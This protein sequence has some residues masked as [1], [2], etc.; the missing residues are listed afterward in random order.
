MA[1]AAEDLLVRIDATTE[2]LRREMRRGDQ[3]VAQSSSKIN[4]SLRRVDGGFRRLNRTVGMAT[5]AM[6]LFGVSIGGAAFIRSADQALKSVQE[7]ERSALALGETT[8]SIQELAYAF[9]QFNLEQDDVNDALNTLADRAQDAV[10]GTQGMIDDFGLL[11]VT[12]DDLRGKSPGELFD[13]IAEAVAGIE[14]PTARSA[15]VV[16]TFGDDLGRKLIPLLMEGA[17]GLKAYRDEAHDLNAVLGQDTVRAGSDAARELAKVRAIFDAQFNNAIAANAGAFSELSDVLTSDGFQTAMNFFA[18][19]MASIATESAKAAEQVGNLIDLFTLD[20][21]P[22]SLLEGSVVGLVRRTIFP[23]TRAFDDDSPREGQSISGNIERIHHGVVPDEEK[24]PS[25]DLRSAMPEGMSEELIQPLLEHNER[26][27]EI[28]RVHQERLGEIRAE[29]QGATL[30]G[31]LRFLDTMKSATDRDL[32][33]Q[34][35]IYSN[36]FEMISAAGARHN[37]EM[38]ELN[39]A[40]G[41]VN[42]TMATYQGAAQAL[43]DVPYPFNFAAAAAVTAAGLARVSAIAGTSFGSKSAPSVS[44]GTAAPPVSPVD[45]GGQ[46]QTERPQQQELLVRIHGRRDDEEVLDKFID[47]LNE[48]LKDG[49]RLS[50]IRRI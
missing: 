13:T 6:G 17:D 47:G 31:Y 21:D 20:V 12:V 34:I 27:R 44:G 42:A 5:R 16:R 11:G 1:I 41:I 37:K 48:R 10:D 2:Q 46:Q 14:D 39:K 4:R 8:D 24:P 32:D 18:D 23:G 43:K 9:G 3:Q 36:A 19:I 50:G 40:A 22:A 25:V 28:E 45:P 38:F 29:G 26:V 33:E 7:I 15:A 49:L 30:A 35:G